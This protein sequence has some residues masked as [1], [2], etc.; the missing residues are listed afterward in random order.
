MQEG[1]IGFKKPKTKKKRPSRRVVEES[2][3]GPVNGATG[4]AD[5]M[6]IDVDAKPTRRA[7]NLDENFIDDDELQAS[8]A[9]AR[10]EKTRKVK[11]MT[12]EEIA[13][14]RK[15]TCPRFFLKF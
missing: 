13:Q 4:G 2:D 6:D 7:R 15:L 5:K 12:Q 10:R 11:V 3:I 9:R 14:K 8:L 1:D